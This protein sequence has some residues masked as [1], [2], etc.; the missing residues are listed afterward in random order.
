ML[1]FQSSILYDNNDNDKEFVCYCLSEKQKDINEI[2]KFINDKFNLNVK[3]SES[4]SFSIE[5]EKSEEPYDILLD[6]IFDSYFAFDDNMD[7]NI[8]QN[9]EQMENEINENNFSGKI[10]VSLQN[11]IDENNSKWIFPNGNKYLKVDDWFIY[12]DFE[13]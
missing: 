3:L 10:C 4:T 8:F 1:Q 9:M 2:K 11:H 5:L 7:W 6:N 13:N 12:Y